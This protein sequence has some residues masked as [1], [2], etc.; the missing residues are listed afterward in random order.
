M[1][2]LCHSLRHL[3]ALL[4]IYPALIHIVLV[5]GTLTFCR[6]TYIN[7]KTISKNQE[8]DKY[9]IQASGFP[10]VCVCV[11]VLRKLC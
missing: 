7:D 9:K 6:Y 2:F 8:N 3:R 1:F 5:L 4:F 11:C 10:G